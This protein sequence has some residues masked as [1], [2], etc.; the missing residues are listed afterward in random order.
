MITEPGVVSYTCDG[1]AQVP[2]AKKDLGYRVRFCLKRKKV[3]G[4]GGRRREK[5]KGN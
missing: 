2:T 5:N 3:K 1:A 4:V